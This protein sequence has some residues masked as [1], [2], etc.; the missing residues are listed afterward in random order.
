V[1]LLASRRVWIPVLSDTQEG[2][3]L[4]VPILLS[5]KGELGAATVAL[6]YDADYLT[7]PQADW[8][9][10]LA[11]WTQVNTNRAGEI[12]LSFA[13]PGTA[14]PSGTQQIASVTFR[15]RSIPQAL[16]SP[17]PLQLLGVIYR[18]GRSVHRGNRRFLRN[19]PAHA[20]QI[21]RR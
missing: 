11:G 21:H 19:G 18:D 17:L 14:V 7:E 5:S 6:D 1:V 4:V 10:F 3:T 15:V 20:A 9:G 12:R 2:G 8:P 16:Q 13:L